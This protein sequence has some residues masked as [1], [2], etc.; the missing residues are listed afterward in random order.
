MTATLFIVVVVVAT[1]LVF[2][3]TNGFHDSSN[4]MATSVATGAF[5]PKRAVLVAAVRSSD[6][7]RRRHTSSSDRSSDLQMGERD[8]NAT[9]RTRIIDA[10]YCMTDEELAARMNIMKL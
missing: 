1:A 5:T 7:S 4:A 3:F 2:D 9:Y 10:V 8:G 6:P